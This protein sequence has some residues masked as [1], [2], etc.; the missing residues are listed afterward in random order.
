MKYGGYGVVDIEKANLVEQVKMILSALRQ[1][2]NTGKKLKA[3]IEYH[4]LESGVGKS[5]LEQGAR[6][7][8]Y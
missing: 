2:D 8:F 7:I 6:L 4:Q 3:L 5:V 1:G